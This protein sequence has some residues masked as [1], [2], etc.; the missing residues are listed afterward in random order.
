MVCVGV[1]VG[2]DSSCVCEV[3]LIVSVRLCVA[4]L[5]DCVCVRVFCVLLVRNVFDVVAF[6]AFPL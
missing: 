3:W 6:V 1:L 5:F 2:D 4:Q